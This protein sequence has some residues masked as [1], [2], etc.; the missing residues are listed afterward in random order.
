MNKYSAFLA[1]PSSTAWRPKYVRNGGPTNFA[2]RVKAYRKAWNAAPEKAAE[3]KRHHAKVARNFGFEY[4]NWIRKVKAEKVEEN[5]KTNNFRKE[6]LE[7]KRS[8]NQAAVNAVLKKYNVP[9]GSAARVS[10]SP[11]PASVAASPA[12]GRRP[13]ARRN[14]TNLRK[15]MAHR[16]LTRAKNALMAAKAN[17]ENKR[18]NLERQITNIIYKIRELPS[19]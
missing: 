2:N 18:N 15:A 7:A 9:R 16:N 13:G 4:E 19:P 11:R 8:G 17:L 6:L 14:T 3:R 10:F 12:P 1:N 5:K